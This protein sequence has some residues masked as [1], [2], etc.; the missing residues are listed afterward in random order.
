M[1][2]AMWRRRRDGD[3]YPGPCVE[4]LLLGLVCVAAADFAGAGA[5]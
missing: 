1:V 5:Y 3:G 2:T 4:D